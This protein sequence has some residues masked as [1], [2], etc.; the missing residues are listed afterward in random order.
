MASD[1]PVQL[2]DQGRLTIAPTDVAQF[3]RLEQCE[4]YLRLRLHERTVDREFMRTYGATP[5]ALPPLLTREGASFE[6]KVTEAIHAH[7]STL[8]MAP[9][10]ELSLI[11]I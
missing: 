5:Q 3:V 8:D 6:Q 1:W 11:H 9:K 4:R 10:G 2:N 7:A